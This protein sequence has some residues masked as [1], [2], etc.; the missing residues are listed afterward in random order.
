MGQAPLGYGLRDELFE[1][2]YGVDEDSGEDDSGDEGIEPVAFT[3]KIEKGES[4]TE[5]GRENEDD[6]TYLDDA[7]GFASGKT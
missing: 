3:Q 6:D 2:S 7:V 5:N 4:N 1:T